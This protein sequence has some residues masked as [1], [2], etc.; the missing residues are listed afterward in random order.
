MSPSPR[1]PTELFR[2]VIEHFDPVDDRPA[3]CNLSS[4]SRL[5]RLEGQRIL[6]DRV[7]FAHEDANNAIK[8]FTTILASPERL[9]LLVK[10]CIIECVDLRRG[11]E[12]FICALKAMVNLTTLHLQ[13]II[14][15]APTGYC[16]RYPFQLE[17]LFVGFKGYDED[18]FT[19]FLPS[20]PR[21]KRLEMDTLLPPPGFQLIQDSVCQDLV[22]LVGDWDVV[23]VFLPGRH[24]ISLML[25]PSEDDEC[26]GYFLPTSVEDLSREFNHLLHFSCRIHICLHSMIHHLRS[27]EILELLSPTLDVSTL[28]SLPT[29]TFPPEQAAKKLDKMFST[30]EMLQW[31]DLEVGTDLL[32]RD[33]IFHRWNRSS[34]KGREILLSETEARRWWKVI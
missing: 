12:L 8:F 10:A 26:R 11:Q 16:Q 22:V 19:V 3:L 7:S 23:E 34:E 14:C 13:P 29:I 32:R 9:A 25:M 4:T 30:C 2:S 17:N 33:K 1:F 24:I 21:L 31:I 5:L 27:L 20:Q 6:Y 28:V 18:L 15:T